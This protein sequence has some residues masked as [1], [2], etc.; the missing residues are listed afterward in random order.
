MAELI[1]EVDDHAQRMRSYY[2]VEKF[3][4]KIGRGYDNDIIL[5]DPHVCA[6]HLVIN[7]SEQG[8]L[9]EDAGS[10]NGVHT[11]DESKK[12]EAINLVSGD[13]LQIGKTSLRFLKPDH[14]VEPAR[15]LSEAGSV[16]DVLKLLSVV[17]ALLSVLVMVFVFDQY[18][19]SPN[20]VHFGKLVADSMVIVA[21]VVLWVSLWSLLG[22]VVGRKLFFLYLLAVTVIYIVADL[23]VENVIDYI[24]FNMNSTLMA[25]IMSYV[26]GGLL[27]VAMLYASM[28]KVLLVSKKRKL[29]LANLFAWLVVVVIGFVVYANTPEF[30]HNPVYAAELKPPFGRVASSMSLQDFFD[31]TET[32]IDAIE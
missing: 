8:W 10:K 12:P 31:Q 32:M 11:G 9:A 13:K 28:T 19:M 4:L 21:G 16:V 3:P 23:M 30:N 1:V 27:L 14:P 26:M 25:D 18:Q 15:L 6:R 24:A 17:W 2:P 22:Y 29:I 7:R 20:K 5:T